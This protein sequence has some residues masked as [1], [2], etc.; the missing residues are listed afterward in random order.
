[1]RTNSV[2]INHLI[3]SFETARTEKSMV[4]LAK[5]VAFL[6]NNA[7]VVNGWRI[8]LEITNERKYDFVR[9]LQ[10]EEKPLELLV[11]K[12]KALVRK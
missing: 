7:P 4:D 6:N 2:S 10:N 11:E 3:Q 5:H 9:Q 12:E 8:Q 1:M